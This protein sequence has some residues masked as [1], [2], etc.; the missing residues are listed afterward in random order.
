[1]NKR[2]DEY[3]GSFENRCRF[4]YEVVQA[5]RS[6]IPD[7]MPFF[8]RADGIDELMEQTMTEEEIVTFINKCA[9]L[10]VDVADLSRGNATSF[11]TVYEVPPFNLADGFKMCIRDRPKA[12]VS[13]GLLIELP[14]QPLDPEHGDSKNQI[15][16]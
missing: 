3:G 4:C 13:A 12:L 14:N 16:A 9:E 6:N 15:K 11:A 8:M 7:D 5:I 10:G 1:M 2:T